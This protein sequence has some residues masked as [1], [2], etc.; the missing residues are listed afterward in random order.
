MEGVIEMSGEALHLQRGYTWADYLQW[1]DAGR[2]EIIAGEAH[3]M[4]PA[5]TP[6]HQGIVREFTRQ[7]GNH[8]SGCPCTVFPSPVDVRLTDADVV[9]P[10]VIVVCTP[11]QIMAT[12]IEGPPTLVIEVLSPSTAL[13]DRTRKVALYAR[14]GVREVW[15][16]TPYPWMVEVLVLDQAAYRFVGAYSKTDT[17]ASPTFP[18]LKIDL[19]K[20]FNFP[21]TPDEHIE[22]VKEVH[23]PYAT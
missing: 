20:V 11:K 4:T 10:D 23:P 19:E 9:Q 12:H 22:M 21:I 13:L 14:S 1:P 15:L 2:W 7:M 3:A 18:E 17:F 5:P 6:R 16:V 8:F